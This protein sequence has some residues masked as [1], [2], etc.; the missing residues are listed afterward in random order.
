MGPGVTAR[1]RWGSFSWVSHHL[2]SA[3]NPCEHGLH[4][5]TCAPVRFELSPLRGS[6]KPIIGGGLCSSSGTSS[7]VKN[8]RSRTSRHQDH[9][10]DGRYSSRLQAGLLLRQARLGPGALLFPC[11]LAGVR[12]LCDGCTAA[13]AALACAVLACCCVSARAC[14]WRRRSQLRHGSGPRCQRS[15][16]ATSMQAL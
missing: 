5:V 1:L 14:T 16:S 13:S 15:C 7:E 10:R 8:L 2:Y 9:L 4:E 11:G 3:A 6:N 12:L